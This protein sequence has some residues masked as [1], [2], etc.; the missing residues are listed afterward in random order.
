MQDPNI[1]VGNPPS[2]EAPDMTVFGEIPGSGGPNSG[3]QQNQPFEIEIDEKFKNLPIEEAKARTWQSRFDK[4]NSEL[5]QYK[6]QLEQA[7]RYQHFVDDLL[8]NDETLE[9]FLAERKP[10]LLQNKK[11]I[12]T[13][14]QDTL[15][16]EFPEFSSKKPSRQEADEN[17][18]ERAWLY[19]KRLEELYQQTKGT[20]AAGKTKTLKELNAER[21]ARKEAERNTTLQ[22]ITSVKTQM[23]WDDQ[24]VGTFYK[25]SQNLK[26][27]DL[28][29][30]FSYALKNQRN[31]KAPSIGTIP[32]QGNGNPGGDPSM[33]PSRQ[34][35]LNSLKQR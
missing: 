27:I 1:S 14:I 33:S 6:G 7:A 9:A 34:A 2:L 20:N 32:G 18:G 5:A 10:E 26:L 4:T 17:P 31:G 28:A 13:V 8:E 25:W 15:K 22:E 16:N 11:D 29:L 23:S 35:F 12:S 3:N 21:E 24:T 19:Y 30:V